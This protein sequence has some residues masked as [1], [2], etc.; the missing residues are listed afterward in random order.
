MIRL[1]ELH[2]GYMDGCLAHP[3]HYSIDTFKVLETIDQ[4]LTYIGFKVS[5][6]VVYKKMSQ[7]LSKEEDYEFD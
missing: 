3:T 7:R 1:Q 6:G 4:A 2:Q 5:K